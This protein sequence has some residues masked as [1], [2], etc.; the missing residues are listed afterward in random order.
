MNRTLR[1][2]TFL[3][4]LPAM[5]SA[6][7]GGG[8]GPSNFVGTNPPPPVSQLV[9][10]TEDNATTVAGV[11]AQQVV[12]DNLIGVLTS[13]GIPVVGAGSAAAT[14]MIAL[15][16]SSPS[17]GLAAAQM[18]LQDCAVSGTV[19]VEFTVSNPSTVTP[20]DEF[21]FE[22]NACND[23][24]GAVLSGGL[25][26]TV[27]GFDINPNSETFYI[28]IDLGLSAFSVTQDGMTSGAD[29]TLSIEIDSRQPPITTITVSASTLTLTNGD[30]TET[31]TDLMVTVVQ[32]E[33]M[34]PSGVSVETSMRLSTPRLGGDIVISTSVALQSFGEEYPYGG[35]VTISG[36]ANGSI[37]LIALD[38]N[39][40]RLE[41]DVDGDGATDLTIDTT[42]TELMAEAA[43]A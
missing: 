1:T 20:G 16:G 15:S 17:P 37:T 22:F 23:G 28:A 43:A 35:E 5:L 40:V 25:V 30:T 27:S 14:E 7:S 10:I 12:E 32:D 6:C 38:G 3:I 13:T 4:F 41:V 24:A 29:G 8:D 39:S 18:T 9:T 11:A 2:T 33:S 34:F 31:V 19:D 21:T 42:W 36:D 26:M